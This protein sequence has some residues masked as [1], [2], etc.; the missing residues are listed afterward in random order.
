VS[1]GAI[2]SSEA[3]AA[4]DSLL[5]AE[6]ALSD[7][8]TLGRYSV[9]GVVPETVLIPEN[10]EQIAAILRLSTERDFSV[11]PFGGGT[12]QIVGSSPRNVSAVISTERLKAVE[13]YDPGDLTISLQAGARVEQVRDTCFEHRQLLPI[14]SFVGSTIGGALAVA[15]SGP[16]RC[17]FGG[18]RD[19]CIGVTFVT[20]DGTIGRGGGRV[21]KNVAGYD[22]MKLM[23]GS[24]GTLGVIT[25]A[26]FKLFPRPA[27]TL[28]CICEFD[29]LA[30]AL[31]FR[32]WI[33][34]SPLS[35][36]A[37][38][39]AS[40][41]VTDYLQDAEPRN[42]DEWAPSASAVHAN[43][44][45]RMM[46][47]FAGS[48]RALARSRADVRSHTA[49]ELAGS[50]ESQFWNRLSS[51]EQRVSRRHL[52]AMIVHLDVPIGESLDAL[53]SAQKAALE[54]NFVAVFIGRAT[55]GSFVV[56]FVPLAIDPP[57]VT[58][59]AGAASAL[60]SCL[61]KS[62]SAVVVRCPREAKQ[63][64]DVWGSTPTDT[65]LMQKIKHALDP[66]GILNRG[67]FLAA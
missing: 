37:A 65:L 52:N 56:S 67:R 5:G 24:Y 41:E 54:Y 34:R 13:A 8:A 47:R 57:A 38:E 2:M 32:D 59:F 31:E 53:A 23:I 50:E 36:I 7:V 42:P 19:F 11:V 14:E 64:F 25:S 46:V 20:G 16:L 33:I 30:E 26:N 45:W 10:A 63:H 43:S 12:R 27:N 21:V 60:R 49:R 9:D 18:L 48:E 4:F 15:A 35:P 62:S 44:A 3:C 66:K 28:T 58:Q 51:F 40:P 22:L 17:G 6:A 55:L 1:Q 29:S 39:L 61:S